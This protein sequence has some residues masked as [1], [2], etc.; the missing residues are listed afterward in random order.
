MTAAQKK[1]KQRK[2]Q[3]MKVRSGLCKTCGAEPLVEG[4]EYGANCLER[5]RVQDRRR[6]GV[7]AWKPGK[8]G[9]PPKSSAMA[10]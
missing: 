3:E 6:K 4:S 5:R 8:P 7:K 2:W 10:F 1:S 9:R